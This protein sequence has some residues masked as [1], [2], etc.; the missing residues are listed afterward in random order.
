[1][2][3]IFDN[4]YAAGPLSDQELASAAGGIRIL[5]KSPPFQDPPFGQ[6]PPGYTLPVVPPGGSVQ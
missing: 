1:M 3:T 5:P 2:K 4:E 6:R